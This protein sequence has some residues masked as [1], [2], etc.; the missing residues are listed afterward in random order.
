MNVISSIVY[1]RKDISSHDTDVSSSNYFNFSV[2]WVNSE[3]V[4]QVKDD[5]TLYIT[6]QAYF[7]SSFFPVILYTFCV[8]CCLCDD[9]T[10]KFLVK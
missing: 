2:R 4:L 10:D 5:M 8:V 3:E 1:F 6:Y 7:W 9:C